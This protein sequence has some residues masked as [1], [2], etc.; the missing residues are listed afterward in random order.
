MTCTRPGYQFCAEGCQRR[1]FLME[2]DCY[3]ECWH[4]SLIMC[5]SWMVMF[6]CD[7]YG[8]RDRLWRQGSVI[9]VSSSAWL[10]VGVMWWS[11]CL[12]GPQKH[13]RTCISADQWRQSELVSRLDEKME[14]KLQGLWIPTGAV[15]STK[16]FANNEKNIYAGLYDLPG[17]T[18]V[19]GW[20]L[21]LPFGN[22]HVDWSD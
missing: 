15:R 22:C 6:G 12:N 11:S 21:L 1:P 8:A 4:L 10:L 9:E 2:T 7:R 3:S 20:C 17:S 5:V 13:C 18:I 14:M 19:P 16:R